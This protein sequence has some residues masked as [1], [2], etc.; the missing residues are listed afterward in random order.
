MAQMPKIMQDVLR[1]SEVL[2]KKKQIVAQMMTTRSQFEPTWKLLSRYINPM[3]GRFEE[4][5]K[6][7]D[8]KRRDYYLL[9]PYPMEACQK[10]GAGL[11]AGLTSP[12]RPW[13]SLGLQDDELAEYHTVKLW[14]EECKD[15]MM[16]IYAKSN[17]YNML[18]NIDA[19][20]SQFGTASALLLED[21]DHAIWARPYTCG[22]YAGDV[23]ARGRVSHFARRFKLTAWQMVQEFGFDVCSE[24][25]KNAYKANNMTAYF[26]VTMLIEQNLKYDP[27]RLAIGNFPWRSYYFEDGSSDRF[28]KV[29]GYHERPFIMPRWTTVANGIYGSGPGHNALGNCMQLQK[30]EKLNMRLLETRAD[31]AMLVPASVGKVD[32]LPGKQTIVPDNAVNLIRPVYQTTGSREDAMQTIQLKQQQIAAA[33]YNDLFVMLSSQD[34]PQMTAREVAER[35][36]EKLLMLSPVLEQL[37]NEV[38]IPLT[39]RTFEIALRNGLFPPVPE[40]LQGQEENLK[41]EF[42]SL[43]A[44]AQRMV[45]SPALEKTLALAGNLAGI[46]PEIVDNIDMDA[47]IRQHAVINGAPEKMMRGEDEVKKIRE[48]RAQAQAQQQ[49]MEQAAAMAKPLRDGVEAARLLSET[50]VT[51]DSSI[52]NAMLGGA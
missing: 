46:A 3:R 4:E 37:H 6:G 21:Y 47:V 2:R 24:Q 20:L 44:Q 52:I 41:V 1:D 14:L 33:F 13:F 25:V 27:G 11:H 35:H 42:I 18:M 15:I 49:Q 29:A 8:G 40:E 22:E 38:L 43:L 45:E 48:Q 31:P 16:G 19:E 36:E 9:E 10:C 34:N 12:S 30:L 17:I 50:P 32:R 28:L 23:D 39:K 5:D 51:E 7:S 26:P